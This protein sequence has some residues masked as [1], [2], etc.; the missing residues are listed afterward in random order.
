MRLMRWVG[1]AACFWLAGCTTIN[2]FLDYSI[3]TATPVVTQA[4]P[5]ITSTP[6]PGATQAYA[7]IP[8]QACP[9]VTLPALRADTPQDGFMAWKPASDGLAYVAARS[10]QEWYVGDLA[11]ASGKDFSTSATLTKD[12]Q[13]AGDML[14]SPDG[15]TIAFAAYRQEDAVYTVMVA[16]E[17]RA[18]VDL[19]PGQAAHTD[20][21][22]SP[23]QVLQWVSPTLLSVDVTCG[24]DCEQLLDVNVTDG[25]ISK[26]GDPVRKGA[27]VPA[28]AATAGRALPTGEPFPPM[29]SQVW[30]PDGSQIAFLD[31]QGNP[32]L[33]S[34]KDFTQYPLNVN[35]GNVM[36]MAWSPDGKL[37]AIRLDGSVVAFK[38]GCG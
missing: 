33:L 21:F 12:I 27:V 9:V 10:D 20:A 6:R 22:A 36:E 23:K 35:N 25:V 28:A 8:A 15:T 30:S 38:M 24:M 7:V 37:L 17:N 11:V 29:S 18:A 2:G 14:W 4:G 16:G 32:W 1:L 31:D 5:V 34:V 26:S 3:R 19:F 13:V